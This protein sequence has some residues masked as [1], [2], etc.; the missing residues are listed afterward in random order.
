MR[1]IG[2]IRVSTQGQADEGISLESQRNKINAWCDLN[3]YTLEQVYSDAGISGAKMDRRGLDNAI[4]NAKPGDALIVYSLSRLTRSTKHMLTI[5]EDLEKRGVDLVSLSERIDTTSAAGRMIFRM[6]AVLGEFEREQVAE[7]TKNALAYKKASGEKYSPVP[8][9]YKEIDGRLHEVQA[10][11]DIVTQ[12]LA[13]R[14][15]G[16]SYRKI[17]GYLNENG[18]KGKRG[19]DW[20]ASTVRYLIN[21][22]AA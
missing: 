16:Q 2:Y 18:I 17:A 1:A 14:E 4:K 9:G 22:Q 8:Y 7:R 3:G 15:G 5:A 10:E 12:V 6:L 20:H 11:A 19:G 13:M 21:R